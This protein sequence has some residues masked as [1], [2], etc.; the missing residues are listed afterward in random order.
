MKSFDTY[1]PTKLIFGEGTIQRIGETAKEY[2]SK[3]M[4]VTTGDDMKNFGILEKVLKSMDEAGVAYEV[5]SDV[6]QNPKDYNVDK[7]VQIYKD[8]GCQM[9]IGLG[10]GSAM[11][12]AK[13]IG[14]VAHNGGVVMD[15]MPGEPR[16]CEDLKVLSPASV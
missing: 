7:G 10:G 15:Y 11:D 14:M 12:A 1:F 3:A 6:E 8:T 13:A 9:T 16:Y 2:G 4:I 5:F